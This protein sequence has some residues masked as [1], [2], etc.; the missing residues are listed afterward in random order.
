MANVRKQSEPKPEVAN[1]MQGKIKRTSTL[2]TIY[3]QDADAWEEMRA[4]AEAHGMSISETVMAG[5]EKL[6][7]ETCPRCT[8]I[9]AILSTGSIK[10]KSEK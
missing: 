9:A 2:K 6:V 1:Y 3:V 4:W 7:N 5:F 8:R 10:V